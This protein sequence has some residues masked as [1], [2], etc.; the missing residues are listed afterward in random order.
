MEAGA[1]LETL[2][3][4]YAKDPALRSLVP[5][6]KPSSAAEVMEVESEAGTAEETDSEANADADEELGGF[7]EQPGGYGRR[8][9]RWRVVWQLATRLGAR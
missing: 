1:I 2:V 9:R 6:L 8:W 7:D 4:E 3:L 5:S